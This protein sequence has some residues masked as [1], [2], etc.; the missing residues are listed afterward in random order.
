MVYIR[1]IITY[2]FASLLACS[3]SSPEKYSKALSPEEALQSFQII[4]GFRA[5]LFASE[6]QTMDP[7]ELVFDEQG[8]VYVVEM[9]DY[10]F[11]SPVDQ[12]GS[13]VRVLEDKDGDGRIDA[14]TIFADG[15][16]EATSVLPWKGGLL[17]CAAPDIFYLKDTNGDNV[18]D[19][20]EVLFTGFFGQNSEAQITNLRYGLDNWIYAAN[21]G[22]KGHIFSPKY[23]ELDTIEVQG[24]DFRFRLEPFDFEAAT[25]ITQFGHDQDDWGHRLV[26]AAY[27]NIRRMITREGR[28][29]PT[30]SVKL[31]EMINY[32]SYNYDLP[33]SLQQPFSVS[34]EMAPA[35]WNHEHQLLQIGLKGFEPDLEERPS[36]NLV[37]L[38]DVSGSMRSADKLGL[39]KKSL[40]LLVNQMNQ[41]DRIALV[42]YAGSAGLVLDSTSGDQKAKIRMAIQSLEAGGST[43][44]GA[45]IRLAYEVAQQH[46]LKDSGEY[47]QNRTTPGMRGGGCSTSAHRERRGGAARR[48]LHGDGHLR[49]A[50]GCPL[51]AD[52]IVRA[53][54]RAIAEGASAGRGPDRRSR[55][56][57]GILD[58]HAR[59]GRERRT[60][61]CV[62]ERTQ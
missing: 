38:V 60:G 4:S 57:L 48:S 7:I 30:D 8:K 61:R 37:F 45:G 17:V 15:L 29:P 26:T 35:P 56:T 43:N 13:R 44:G 22:Q 20:K 3:P 41:D 50:P 52:A 33:D 53:G 49:E 36:A 21:Y 23:P 10:P 54:T 55:R 11:K 24:A 19:A 58:V 1:L 39:V 47:G 59:T 12:G 5:E 31:E 27:S 9:P 25:G 14:S 6:P 40:L 34:V 62:P 2:L 16:M 42:V 46:Y 18:A 28:L 32:F 51:A